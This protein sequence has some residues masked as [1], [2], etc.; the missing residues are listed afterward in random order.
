MSAS[1]TYIWTAAWHLVIVTAAALVAALAREIWLKHAESRF[2]L[3][4]LTFAVITLIQLAQTALAFWAI[5]PTALARSFDSLSALL[6]GWGLAAPFLSPTIKRAWLAGGLVATALLSALAFGPGE[7]SVGANA[8]RSIVEIAATGAAAAALLI[9]ARDRS[10]VTIGAL[11]VLAVGTLVWTVGGQV[12][13]R[14]LW[15]AAFITLPVGVMRWMLHDLESAERELQ[16]FSQHA[17]RQTQELLVLMR[18]STTLVAQT[19]I[20]AM[21]S[22]A[23]EGIALGAGADMVLIA[24]IGDDP[25]KTVGVMA[26][27]PPLT[28]GESISFPLNSHAVIAQAVHTNQ[29][30]ILDPDIGLEQH[31]LHKLMGGRQAGPAIVQPMTSQDKTI[32]VIIAGN[33]HERR[34]LHESASR[35]LE[36]LGAQIATAVENVRMYHRLNAQARELAHLLTIREEEASQRAAILESIADGVVVTDKNDRIILINPAAAAI[37]GLERSDLIGRASKDALESIIPLPLG[38][39]RASDD[40]SLKV[41][42][43]NL[44]IQERSVQASVAPVQTAAGELLGVV[45]VLRDITRERQAERAKT[46]FIATISHE[47]RTPLTSIKGYADLINAGVGGE[48][49]ETQKGFMG[50]I[51]AQADHLVRLINQIIHY[52]E[53]ERGAVQAACQPVELVE[54]VQE[55][56][57]SFRNRLQSADFQVTLNAASSLPP[58]YADPV[59]TRQIIEQLLD[60]ALRFTP[61]PGHIIISIHPWSSTAGGAPSHLALDLSDTGVGIAPQDLERIFER[62]YRADNPLQVTAGGLGLGLAIARALA[63]AQGGQ[64]FAASPAL[65]RPPDGPGDHP[66]ATFTLRLPLYKG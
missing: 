63:V 50:K 35:L 24:L 32:G 61:P 19:S 26:S 55:T 38:V 52:S 45:A 42:R 43:V 47:L 44:E 14:A 66:G 5:F 21:L 9:K 56:L 11:M 37:L 59:R 27:Y 64:L 46:E 7:E 16:A 39:F 13:G 54:I 40:A 57:D 8:L 4:W 41:V 65:E 60:N 58:V 36:A 49:N 22:E 51:C 6:V 2:K 30:T 23:V 15:L 53:L 20:A 12:V 3:T 17:L 48:L 31:P 34:P 1:P 28:S 33:T 29:Q 10:S 62:F 18:S 25:N